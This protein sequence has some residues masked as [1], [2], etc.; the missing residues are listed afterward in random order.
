MK[1]DSRR[2]TRE[3]RKISVEYLY[4]NDDSLRPFKMAK[5]VSRVYSESGMCLY[6]AI[7]HTEGEN[8]KFTMFSMW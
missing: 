3:D 2:F 6:T 1:T 5:A 4:A 8:I 7:D